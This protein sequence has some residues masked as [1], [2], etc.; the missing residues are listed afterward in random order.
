MSKESAQR[1][2]FCREPGRQ[3]GTVSTHGVGMG[4][5][6]VSAC[7]ETGMH[8]DGAVPVERDVQGQCRSRDRDAQEWGCSRIVLIPG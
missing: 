7:P 8:G 1:E 5:L 2:P 6:G 4:M 3:V